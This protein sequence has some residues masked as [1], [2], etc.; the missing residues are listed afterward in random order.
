MRVVAFILILL[1]T[2]SF[3]LAGEVKFVQLSDVHYTDKRQSGSGRMLKES[4]QLLEAAVEQINEIKNLD[5][6]VFTGDIINNPDKTLSEKFG[7][8]VNNLKPKWYWTTGNHDVGTSLTKAEFVLMMNSINHRQ[9][10]K[11]YYYFEIDEFIFIVMDGTIDTRPSS[12]AQFSK[13]ELQWLEGVLNKYS[14]KYAVI[15][16][17]FPIIEP[18]RSHTH[19]IINAGEYLELLD[20]YN[21]ILAVFSGHYHAAKIRQRKGVVHVSSPALVQYPNAFRL[22]TLKTT[23]DGVELKFE[24]I[25]TSEEDIK[26]TSFQ[27]TRSSALH[28][29][30]E[31]DRNIII[32]FLKKVD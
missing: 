14:G 20:K 30:I 18:F 3:A 22:I 31:R 10:A 11:P 19:D 23:G 26:N 6:V 28:Y 13:E 4:G 9:R 24:F 8:V 5:F 17:H 32:H 27:K 25:Q 21:N 2:G 16:Q 12:N 15:F 1:F 29:G 7:A